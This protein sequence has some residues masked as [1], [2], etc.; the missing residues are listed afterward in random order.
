VRLG[1]DLDNTIIDYTRAFAEAARAAGAAGPPLAGKTALRAALR[2][3]PGGD[4]EWQRLQA[5]VYGPLIERAEPFPGVETFFA[6]ARERDVPFAIVSHKSAFAGAAPDGPNLRH[7]A[8]TWLAVRG[9]VIAGKPAVYFEA[10]RAEKCARIAAL[11]L[12]HFVDDLVE[13]FDDPG[14]P[15]TCE[16]WLFA[17]DGAPA[18]APADRIFRTWA[19]LSD[20]AL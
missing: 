19:E 3:G 6:R 11:G 2:A 17:P 10:T 15:K 12:T 8:S 13:V 5:L 7:C 1:I 9:L 18:D 20:A 4:W 16:R 14:F